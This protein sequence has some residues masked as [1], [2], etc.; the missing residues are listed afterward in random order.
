MSAEEKKLLKDKEEAIFSIDEH[1][2]AKRSFEEFAASKPNAE[3]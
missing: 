2:E 3:P 1:L